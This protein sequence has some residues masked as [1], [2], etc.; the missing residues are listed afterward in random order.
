MTVNGYCDDRFER[1]RDAFERNF[2]EHGERGASVAITVDGRLVVDLW[3]GEAD[4]KGRPWQTDTIVNV[5]ST[6]KG[7]A[8]TAA[9]ML[10]D[11]GLLDV[12]DPVT[13]YWPSFG[14]DMPVR[15]LLTHQ[16]GLPVIDADVRPGGVTDWDY[17]CKLLEGQQPVWE[18]GTAHGYHAV[19]YGWL[20]GEVVR[21]ISGRSLGT[22]I[23]EEITRPLGADFLLGVPES[24]DARVA[25][26]LRPTP[27]LPQV[28]S[29][30][31]QQQS[32]PPAMAALM[33]PDS[34]AARALGLAS[35][36]SAPRAN[37]REWRAAEIPGANGH[38][39]ARALAR[40]Y[41]E[42]SCDGGGLMSAETVRRAATEHASGPDKVLLMPSRRALGF[43][44]PV[45]EQGDRRP[46]HCF[47]HGGAGGS[48]GFA[49]PV[50]RMGFGYA[51][52]QMWGGGLMTPDPRAQ[53]LVKAAYECLAS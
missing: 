53:S 26:L 45:A 32:A 31:G 7:L 18:P 19:T 20:V 52:N 43:M 5:Y 3:G 6:T 25:T 1:V 29:E 30:E 11:R 42:L 4:A 41:G 51:M 28:E 17:M 39:N 46:E 10:V 12:D 16:A 37:S 49:D 40:V 21:R 23:R 22:F 15:Y 44:K 48:M 2:S 50:A 24:E 34:L 27:T 13:K 33:S 8:A 47:G 35:P 36:P 9:H 14:K 38:A